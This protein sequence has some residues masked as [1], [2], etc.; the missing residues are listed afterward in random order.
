[1]THA[2][3]GRDRLPGTAGGWWGEE[4]CTYIC[5]CEA[6]ATLLTGSDDADHRGRLR[7][8]AYSLLFGS[9]LADGLEGL[10]LIV[11]IVHRMYSSRRRSHRFLPGA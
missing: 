5:S 6:T 1:M 4:Q 10:R 9:F 7:K 8:T 11:C 3:A 2:G